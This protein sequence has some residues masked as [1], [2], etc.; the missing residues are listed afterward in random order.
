MM[1]KQ[2]GYFKSKDKIN[3]ETRIITLIPY[4]ILSLVSMCL[5]AINNNY[6]IDKS[7]EHG[8]H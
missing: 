2:L 1:E 5:V 4:Q 3:M 8:I 6:N 7:D